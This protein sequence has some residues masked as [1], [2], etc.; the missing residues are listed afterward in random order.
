MIDRRT[1]PFSN[2]D[3]LLA[4]TVAIAVLYLASAW[5]GRLTPDS[6]T[7]L[8]Q[9]LSG[10]YDD[11]HPPF[12]A[13]LWR[14]IGATAPAMLAVQVALH[15]AGVW[16]FAEGVRRERGGT[17][18][19][20]VL[21]I[22]LTP[23]AFRYVGVLQKDSLL[24]GLFLVGFGSAFLWPQR[25]F[26][27]PF[28]LAAVLCRANGGF[29]LPPLLF[30]RRSRPMGMVATVTASLALSIVAIPAIGFV[31]SRLLPAR[32]TGVVRSVQLFDLAG[33]VHRGGDPAILPRGAEDAAACYTPLFWDSLT[34]CIAPMP[35]IEP[36]LTRRWLSAI[37]RHP[38]AYAAHRIDHFNRSIFFVVPPMQ[39]CV[40]APAHHR[41]DR[42]IRGRL[43][44]VLEKNA[45]LWPVTWLVA[46][47]VLFAAP[48]HRMA[49]A[50]TVSGLL[51]GYAYLV[52]GVAADFRYFYWTELAVQLAIVL[53]LAMRRRIANARWIAAATLLVWGIGYGA[54]LLLA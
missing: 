22:G 6:E 31:N 15:W 2:R 7:Q 9:A 34:H 11:W 39:Q 25:L 3:R 51:Y 1:V 41:C 12:M 43:R 32:E 18:P 24:A 19:Y 53:Q 44:D 42:S 13:M 54:R 47:S 50:L 38:L 14:A 28:G 20:A 46:G 27:W 52:V 8:Q 26:A 48:L 10:R 45:L 36:S 4:A 21:A 37:V 16:L 5:P 35:Q 23:I 49:R 17:W 30:E 29:A 33:I 40:E